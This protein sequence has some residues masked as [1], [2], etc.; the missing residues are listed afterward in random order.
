MGFLLAFPYWRFKF[1]LKPL[2]QATTLM[3]LQTLLGQVFSL[4][5]LPL[6]K[7]RIIR[8]KTTLLSSFKYS[9]HCWRKFA[10]C[11]YKTDGRS[12]QLRS[13]ITSVS[14]RSQHIPLRLMS[15]RHPKDINKI[16]KPKNNTSCL[17]IL[18][19]LSID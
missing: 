10:T 6:L 5:I 18:P 15:Q 1:N 17:P 14:D 3:G 2:L 12:L 19:H 16:I 8:N 9:Y 4:C 11:A 13:Y 7:C